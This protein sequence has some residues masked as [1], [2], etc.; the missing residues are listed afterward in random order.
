MKYFRTYLFLI[1]CFLSVSTAVAQIDKQKELEAKRQ[2]ILEEIKQIN[3]LLFK[4]KKET[5]TSML[6][7]I[8][9]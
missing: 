3:S 5:V 2:A 6:Y 1:L 9:L 4:T 7:F 8:Q